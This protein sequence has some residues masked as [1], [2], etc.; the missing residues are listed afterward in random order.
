M[1][2]TCATSGGRPDY[3]RRITKRGGVALGSH[4][5]AR[6]KTEVRKS[7]ADSY[8]HSA[9]MA[10]I[11]SERLIWDS[12]GSAMA[13]VHFAQ[14]LYSANGTSGPSDPKIKPRK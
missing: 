5:T 10:R 3:E 6:V 9:R 1:A 14:I 8:P 7:D 2:V 4:E 11:C 12:A 13:Y